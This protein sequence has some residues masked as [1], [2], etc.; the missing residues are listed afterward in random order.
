MTLTNSKNNVQD[1]IITQSPLQLDS[2]TCAFIKNV[3]HVTTTKIIKFN[4]HSARGIMI[5]IL[6]CDSRLI[7]RI[8]TLLVLCLYEIWNWREGKQ[9]NS[10]LF[11]IFLLFYWKRTIC[12]TYAFIIAACWIGNEMQKCRTSI[13][14]YGNLNDKIRWYCCI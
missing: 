9:A 2:I 7:A 10:A 12:I 14:Y 6:N 8:V 1:I 11:G 3:N 4:L 13:C 5:Q